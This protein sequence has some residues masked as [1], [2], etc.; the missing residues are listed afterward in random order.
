MDE[1]LLNKRVVGEGNSTE[2]PD[3]YI[4]N[5]PTDSPA[6]QAQQYVEELMTS[7]T[8]ALLDPES[9]HLELRYRR[10]RIRSGETAGLTRTQRIW[11]DHFGLCVEKILAD[12][13]SFKPLPGSSVEDHRLVVDRDKQKFK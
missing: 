13:F 7:K 11:E 3:Y 5:L 2:S 1:R 12:R 10:E 6:Y 8:R 9:I 4:A